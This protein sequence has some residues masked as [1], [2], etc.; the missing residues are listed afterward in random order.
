MFSKKRILLLFLPVLMFFIFSCGTAPLPTSDNP[1]FQ[2]TA[3]YDLRD[4]E[5]FIQVTNVTPGSI[6]LHVQIFNTGF[7]CVENNFYDS[8]TGNDTHVY[9]MRDIQ[10]NNLA[11]S[12]VNLLPDAYGF[13]V[14]S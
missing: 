1:S 13:V 4:R 7:D 3:F 10:T 9:N 12:G 2:L 5:S 11:P 6:T 14:I 8:L